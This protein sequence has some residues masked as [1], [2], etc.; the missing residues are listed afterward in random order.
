MAKN[1]F[2]KKMFKTKTK[3]E[4]E[5]LKLKKMK[6]E[7]DKLE[8]KF[9]NGTIANNELEKYNQLSEEI[10]KM[11][12]KFAIKNG[13]LVLNTPAKTEEVKVKNPEESIKQEQ[14]VQQQQVI[15]QNKQFRAQQEAQFRAQQEAQLRAQQEAQ[16]RA[17]QEAEMRVE[18]EAQLRAEQVRQ[19]QLLSQSGIEIP[20]PQMS[21]QEAQMRA[22]QQHE[23]QLRAQQEAQ[24]IAQQEAQLRA[25][26]EAQLRAQQE[27]QMKEEQAEEMSVHVFMSDLPELKLLIRAGE[28]NAF[29]SQ[30]DKAIMEGDSK[31][32]RF[33]PYNLVPSKIIMYSFS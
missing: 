13:K 19:A 30:I 32:F 5:I 22:Q 7:Y 23:A 26:Q 12:E 2:L 25:Q 3:S 31:I 24:L 20:K 9:M 15:D 21:P 27:S 16:F 33:G 17:Q 1:N 29:A 11:T 18:H 4:K 8:T 14:V 6:D 28:K 10:K